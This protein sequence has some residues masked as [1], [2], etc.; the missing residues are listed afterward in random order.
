MNK[1]IQIVIVI[2]LT[3]FVGLISMNRVMPKQNNE[4]VE[5]KE[6]RELILEF[7]KNTNYKAIE[8]LE[9][10]TIK[11]KTEYY[12][13]DDKIK[14]DY[15]EKTDSTIQEFMEYDPELVDRMNKE[16]E[17]KLNTFDFYDTTYKYELCQTTK[18]GKC[19]TNFDNK[20]YVYYNTRV[21]EDVWNESTTF[22]EIVEEIINAK[23][24]IKVKV[25][26]DA[27]EYFIWVEKDSGAILKMEEKIGETKEIKTYEIIYDVVN[28]E[29]VKL[30][31]LSEYNITDIVE[32]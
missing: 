4:T 15:V 6:I 2:V 14:V 16:L 29:D 7:S 22:E 20:K 31:D 9:S 10:G 21:I 12:R 26:N 11:S 30:F 19:S 1:K 23:T 28:E 18:T 24:C 27:T 17:E 13:Y 25:I 32:Q 3:V 8:L 5:K